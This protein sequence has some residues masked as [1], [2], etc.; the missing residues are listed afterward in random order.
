MAS[1]YLS[2]RAAGTLALTGI[3]TTNEVIVSALIPGRVERLLVSQGDSVLPDQLVAELAPGE[4]AADRD[5]FASSAGA[6]GS[7][8]EAS[9]S[10]GR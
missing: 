8:V 9:C 6:M 1:T 4:L 2:R 10:G 3:V 5:Y 7:Q